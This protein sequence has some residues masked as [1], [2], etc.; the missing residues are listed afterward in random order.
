[1]TMPDLAAQYAFPPDVVLQIIAGDALLLKLD[2][3][4]VFAL[5]AT[6]AEI[7]QLLADRHSLGSII[8][9]LCAR[10]GADR[11]AIAADVQALVAALLAKGLLE[12]VPST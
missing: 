3:E 9:T 8:D 10:F 7:A 2:R 11:D 1:M 6:G 5:N 4:D 12:R